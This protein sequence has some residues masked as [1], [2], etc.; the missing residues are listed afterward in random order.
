[1]NHVFGLEPKTSRSV[2]RKIDHPKQNQIGGGSRILLIQSQ[3]V[4]TA[5]QFGPGRAKDPVR[6]GVAHVLR[7]LFSRD[8]DLNRIRRG[9]L[10]PFIP[11]LQGHLSVVLRSRF[12]V[13]LPARIQVAPQVGINTQGHIGKVAQPGHHPRDMIGRPAVDEQS[14]HPEP[15]EAGGS[16][17]KQIAFRAAPV[18]A[19]DAAY[20]VAA[21]PKT[22]PY[23]QAKTGLPFAG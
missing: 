13:E 11:P 15:L 7:N 14:S 3:R 9:R 1:M 19:E 8:L 23:G 17:A 12:L 5:D 6:P 20:P 18:L 2:D 21:A 10:R 4:G 22:E 16:P